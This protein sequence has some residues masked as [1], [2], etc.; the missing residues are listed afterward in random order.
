M[1]VIYQAETD[2]HMLQK[3]GSISILF[4][5]FM[6]PQSLLLISIRCSSLALF[7]KNLPSGIIIGL[8]ILGELSRS[9]SFLIE[10]TAFSL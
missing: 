6:L 2:P 5:Y 1:L 7:G 9:S 3:F 4:K 10:I 8:G